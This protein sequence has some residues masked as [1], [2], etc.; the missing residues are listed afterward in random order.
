MKRI[1]I[2]ENEKK[3]K[4]VQTSFDLRDNHLNIIEKLTLSQKVKKMKS[5]N[6]QCEMRLVLNVNSID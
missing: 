3:E 1:A 5:K 2:T 6:R 4:E